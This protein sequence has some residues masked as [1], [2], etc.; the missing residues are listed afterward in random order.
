MSGRLK[1]HLKANERFF[2]NGGVIRVDRKVGIELLNDVVFLLENHVMQQEAAT[3]P[4]HQLYFFIQSMLIEPATAVE[5]ERLFN[6]TCDQL[7]GIVGG[8]DKVQHLQEIKALVQRR[9]TFEAL[10][11]TRV[12]IKMEDSFASSGMLTCPPS[13][14]E[15]F[16]SK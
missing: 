6:I 15:R 13:P 16:A 5:A 7:L 3:T 8:V 9:R 2:I 11:M 4:F 1:L 14:A 12:L 10:R